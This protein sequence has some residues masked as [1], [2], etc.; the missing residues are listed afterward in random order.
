MSKSSTLI[1]S[2]LLLALLAAAVDLS[3]APTPSERASA[4]AMLEAWTTDTEDLDAFLTDDIAYRDP[5]F[6]SVNGHQEYLGVIQTARRSFRDLEIETDD[7]ILDGDR[8]AL[9][10]TATCTD[11]STGRPI[12]L[13]AVSMLRFEG[14]KIAEEWRVYDSANFL[15]Q[16]GILPSDGDGASDGD[17]DGS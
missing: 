14:G 17:G 4:Q 16:L 9:S 1:L 3:G 8:G 5:F 10:W 12:R 6:A 7:F 11:A 13:E 2:T 15:R